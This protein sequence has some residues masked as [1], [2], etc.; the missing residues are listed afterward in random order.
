MRIF[1]SVGEPSGDLHASNL[2]RSL[3]AKNPDIECVGYG[4]PKM[5][6]AGCELHFDL[7][8]LAVMFLWEALKKIRQFRQLARDAENY[9]KAK[10]V[11]AVVLIDYPGFNWWIAKRAKKYGIPVFFYGVP[12]MWAWGGWRIHKL[13]KRVDHVLCKLPFEKPWFEA[14]NVKATYVGHPFFDQ[15]ANQQFDDDFMSNLY[16]S[17]VKKLLLLPGSRDQEVEKHLPTL[18]KSAEKVVAACPETQVSVACYNEKQFGRAQE[19]LRGFPESTAI[20]YLERTPELMKSADVCMACSGSV[21]LELMYHRKPTVIVYHPSSLYMFLQ[22]YLLK[23]KYIT[24]VNLIGTERIE[25]VSRDVYDPDAPGSEIA[26]MPEYLTTDDKTSQ[27]A[28]HVIRWFQDEQAFREKKSRLD[29]M[30]NQYAFPGATER[31]ATYV[32][33]ILQKLDYRCV[34]L[35][36]EKEFDSTLLDGFAENGNLTTEDTESRAA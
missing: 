25:R 20:L 7:T 34:R 1:F 4:G 8:K 22:K 13:K 19:I 36:S 11:D 31:A 17:G 30:A 5:A 32:L 9:F 35:D 6:A 27:M 28:Q 3:K 29:E 26:V 24:L 12:Q 10:Q 14:R 21:S 23:I 33:E 18:L 2:I 15:L 16:V